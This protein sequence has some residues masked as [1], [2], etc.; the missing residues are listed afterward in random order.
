M[1]FP[2][3]VPLHNHGNITST[4]IKVKSTGIKRKKCEQQVFWRTWQIEMDERQSIKFFLL[5][6]NSPISYQTVG[7][8]PTLESTQT[9]FLAMD[10]A[11]AYHSLRS[12]AAIDVLPP[13]SCTQNTVTPPCSLLCLL[14]TLIVCRAMSIV[15]EFVDYFDRRSSMQRCSDYSCF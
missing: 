15:E 13:S 9:S 5:Y 12:I 11:L 2:R 1:R 3:L 8:P 6:P 4:A 7:L 10:E 14:E